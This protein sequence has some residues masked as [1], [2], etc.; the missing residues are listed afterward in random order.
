MLHFCIECRISSFY[1]LKVL[2]SC[3]CKFDGLF[4]WSEMIFQSPTPS[5]VEFNWLACAACLMPRGD[6]LHKG[7]VCF[8]SVDPANSV[9]IS[10][11]H[12]R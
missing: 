4:G 11:C 5:V 8:W 2:N 10:S 7:S 6:I 3:S 9:L 12:Y 1:H